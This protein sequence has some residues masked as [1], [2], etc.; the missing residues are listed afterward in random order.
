MVTSRKILK[1]KDNHTSFFLDHAYERE[2][3]KQTCPDDSEIDF[4]YGGRGKR[5]K[6]SGNIKNRVR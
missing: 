3:F 6:T 2:E 4:A 1:K 5:P